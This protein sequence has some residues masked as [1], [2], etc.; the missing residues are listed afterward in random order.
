M[1]VASH[2]CSLVIY[3]LGIIRKTNLDRWLYFYSADPPLFESN[4]KLE[5]SSAVAA[6]GLRVQWSR[7]SHMHPLLRLASSMLI[8]WLLY[9][10]TNKKYFLNF[11]QSYKV[12]T[13]DASHFYIQVVLHSAYQIGIKFFFFWQLVL[14]F[15]KFV[16]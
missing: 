2:L 14:S 7:A 6:N 15:L 13:L 16:F 10:Y 9:I 4:V 11:N 12:Q 3:Y 1:R 5:V 8:F